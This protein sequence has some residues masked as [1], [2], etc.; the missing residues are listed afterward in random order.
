M[1]G[2][3]S[4]LALSLVAAN[5]ATPF[6]RRQRALFSLP[7]LGYYRWL[8]AVSLLRLRVLRSSFAP[9][10]L[11]APRIA[12]A[13]R[14]DLWSRGIRQ[15]DTPLRRSAVRRNM[16]G[17]DDLTSAGNLRRPS[18][19][20]RIATGVAGDACRCPCPS[21]DVRGASAPFFWGQ[22]ITRFRKNK[23]SS[24]SPLAFLYNIC[25][26]RRHEGK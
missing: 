16:G 21:T 14:L 17:K 22:D 13:S 15:Q 3:V 20:R 9:P 6:A 25:Y 23:K 5:I 7:C 26:N 4:G 12:P 10:R 2:V 19:C 8:R 18:R 24:P 11:S 1:R